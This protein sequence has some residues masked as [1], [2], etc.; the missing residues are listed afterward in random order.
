[1]QFNTATADA[2]R[3]PCGPSAHSLTPSQRGDSLDL[4]FRIRA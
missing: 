2:E 1:V 3:Q 4:L